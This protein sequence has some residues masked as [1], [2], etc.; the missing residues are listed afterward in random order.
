[1]FLGWIIYDGNNIL[2]LA[3][4]YIGADYHYG[5]RLEFVRKENLND[6]YKENVFLW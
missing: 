4:E 5:L 2:L 3:S 6:L 1:M